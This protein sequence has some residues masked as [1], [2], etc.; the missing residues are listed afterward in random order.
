[1]GNTRGRVIIDN[2]RSEGWKSQQLNTFNITFV[3]FIGDII[4][5]KQLWSPFKVRFDSSFIN[6]L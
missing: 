2:G 3:I 6:K 4:I 5:Y 1:M